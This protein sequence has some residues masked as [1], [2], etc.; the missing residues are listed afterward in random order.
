MRTQVGGAFSQWAERL[1][2]SSSL[3]SVNVLTRSAGGR[4]VRPVGGA[5]HRARARKSNLLARFE[6]HAQR[7]GASPQPRERERERQ[8]DRETERGRRRERVDLDQLARILKLMRNSKV[9]PK[10]QKQSEA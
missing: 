6:T 8:S 5:I 10:N 4:G 3:A 7:Q 9:Q 1:T 2:E